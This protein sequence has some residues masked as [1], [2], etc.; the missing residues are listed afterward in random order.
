MYSVPVYTVPKPQSEKLRMVVDH[1]AGSPSLNDM[2]TCNAISGTKMDGM[3]SLGASLLEYR[4][5]HPNVPLILFKSDISMAYRR[6]PM[7]PM[8]QLKQIVTHPNGNHHVDHCNNFGGRGSCKVWVSFMSL[9]IWIAIFVKLVIWIAIF[10]KLL[11]HLKLYVDDSYGFDEQKNMKFYPRYNKWFPAK[12]T[13]LLLL[14]DELGLPHDEP[15]QIFGTTLEIIGFLVN[16]N[17]M[18]VLFPPEKRTELLAHIRT[19]AVAGK[20]WPLHEFL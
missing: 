4:K 20:R 17:D 5:R 1:S 12:Q 18:T 11:A 15:K 2:I 19:F 13:D 8:W 10:V 6:M 9:V 16:P 7:H 3:R 14:W